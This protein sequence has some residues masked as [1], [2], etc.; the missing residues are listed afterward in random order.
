MGRLRG[1]PTQYIETARDGADARAELHG[2]F[3]MNA[4]FSVEPALEQLLADP[5][6]ERLTIDLGDLSFIDSTGIG[7]LLRMQSEAAPRGVELVLLPG[8]P[9]V[10][11][12]FET[13]GLLDA[14]PFAQ[15]S[16]EDAPPDD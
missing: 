6:P 16:A 1:V 3:D 2:E 9:E 4:T 8:P 15:R 14:F 12:V 10:Q 13:A 5:P 11:R 7:V